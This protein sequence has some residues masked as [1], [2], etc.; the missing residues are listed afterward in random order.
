MKEK[1]EDMYE[2]MFSFFGPQNW[3][4]ADTALEVMIGAILAQNTNWKNVEKAIS[5]LKEKELLDVLKLYEIPEQELSLLI[6]P[7]GYFKVKA[8]RIKNLISHIVKNY[9]SELSNFFS[10]DTSSLRQELLSIKG[11]GPETADSIIL[12]AAKKPIFVVD[13]YTYRIMKRHQM[14]WDDITYDELQQLFMENLPS[15]ESLFNEFHALIVETGKH[16]CKKKPLCNYVLFM[17]GLKN[18]LYL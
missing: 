17:V 13:A 6:R 1:L 14:I 9:N 7:A 3:W 16:F 8:K 15:D 4:P 11:I 5:N 2:R 12:Y 10:L 18:N